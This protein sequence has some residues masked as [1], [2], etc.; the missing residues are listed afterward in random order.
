MNITIDI[1]PLAEKYRSGI[2]EYTLNLVS[3]LLRADQ[4]NQYTFF[5]NYFNKNKATNIPNFNAQNL[6]IVNPQLP[7]KLLNY[8][9]FK[10]LKYPNISRWTGQSDIFLMPNW[11]FIAPPKQGHKILAVHDLSFL[12]NR[13]FFSY[14]RLLWHRLINVPALLQRFDAIVAV[15]KNTKNDLME[16]CGVPEKKIRVIYSGADHLIKSVNAETKQKT[17]QK[18][19]LPND[20]ILFLGTLEPRK[21]ILGVI[22]SYETLRAKNHNSSHFK[23]VLAGG[24]GWKYAP[25]KKAI[26]KSR[27][28]DDIL[29]LG[30]IDDADKAALY[31]LARVFLYPSFYE[32][33]GFP[34]LEA[35]TQGCPVVASFAPGLNETIG[36]AGILTNADNHAEIAE[37]LNQ[38]IVNQNLRQNLIQKG[39]AQVKKFHWDK[40]AHEYLELMNA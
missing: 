26:N 21:N 30:F 12:R 10:T 24:D 17:I 13:D 18:Y 37:A 35:M 34:P 19:N 31:N 25:I 2:P 23:L 8:A 22:K 1:R 39:Y 36:N 33:F 9:F 20:F 7:N 27:F 4:K 3:A 28:A 14:R 5:Y 32:G 15:S 38:V 16:L 6:K 29:H 11:N 40:T